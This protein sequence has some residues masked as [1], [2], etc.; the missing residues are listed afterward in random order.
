LRLCALILAVAIDDEQASFKKS[1]NIT[2]REE[3]DDEQAFRSL[4][5]EA[6][7]FKLI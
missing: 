1:L 2:T 5:E 7:Q 3:E 6:K 4:E